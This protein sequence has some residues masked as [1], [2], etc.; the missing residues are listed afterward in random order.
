MAILSNEA[1]TLI[2]SIHPGMVATADASG[3]PNVSPKGS[4]MVLDDEHVAFADVHSPH[5]IANLR[6]NPQVSAIVY[7]AAT[8]HGCRVW[9]S[10]EI[11]TAGEV[12]DKINTG[13]AARNMKANHVV[14]VAVDEYL[15]F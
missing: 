3:R 2:A 14:V 9:G 13:L 4:F 8:R 15:T 7:D 5:T 10:A 6:L 11:L 1:K 12:F